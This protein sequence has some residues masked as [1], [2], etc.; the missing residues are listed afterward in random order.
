[1]C[2]RNKLK[3]KRLHDMY[4]HT[5]YDVKEDRITDTASDYVPHQKAII[6]NVVRSRVWYK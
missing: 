3:G 2:K 4:K 1:M 6:K 5:S